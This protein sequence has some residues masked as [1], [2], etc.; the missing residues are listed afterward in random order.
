MKNGTGPDGQSED[1][2]IFREGRVH[3]CRAMCSTCIF[4]PGNLMHLGDGAFEQVVDKAVANDST[5][6]CHS[7]LDGDNAACRG[8]FD[9]HKTLPL[10]IAEL[11]GYVEE[12]DPPK[13]FEGKR[14][15][16]ST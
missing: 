9:N 5:V 10:R 12:V 3:V 13:L 1:H 8:F 11:M 14:K 2:K 16:P 15:N 4:R 7:T 6:I